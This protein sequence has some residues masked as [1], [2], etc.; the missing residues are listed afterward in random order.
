MPYHIKPFG[1]SL[2]QNKEI[3][4]SVIRGSEDYS[5]IQR[6]QSPPLKDYGN[7]AETRLRLA[8]VFRF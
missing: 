8:T 3:I 6:N 4:H 7:L 2:T 1:R 5:Q